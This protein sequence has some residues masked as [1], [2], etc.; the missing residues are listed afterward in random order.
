MSSNYIK[1]KDEI[2]IEESSP[3]EHGDTKLQ[4]RYYGGHGC[5]GGGWPYY[6]GGYYGGFGGYYGG[7]YGDYNYYSKDKH[8]SDGV[9]LKSKK[10]DK[11]KTQDINGVF[12]RSEI[13]IIASIINHYRSMHSVGNLVEDKSIS[14]DSQDWANYLMNTSSFKHSGNPAYGENLAYFKGYKLDS[15]DLIQKSIEL[16][17][18][19][20]EKYDFDNPGFSSETGH[21]TTLVWKNSQ[22]FG[23]GYAYNKDTDESYVV[24]NTYKPGNYIGEFKDNV[25]PQIEIKIPVVPVVPAVPAGDQVK[26]N[27][28]K[29]KTLGDLQEFLGQIY[30]GSSR[31][32]LIDKLQRIIKSIQNTK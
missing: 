13:S 8:R 4:H 28:F 12:P 32:F 27:I 24:F 2:K 14:K 31:R 5:Y 29:Q 1:L 30:I 21:F 17:Y 25:L 19:E 9:S 23:I 20:I 18:K 3:E 22:S 10:G 16:W 15:I 7:Y 11:P 6:G 26:F